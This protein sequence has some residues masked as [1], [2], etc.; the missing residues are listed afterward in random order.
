MDNAERVRLS[1][2]QQQFMKHIGAELKSIDMGFCE[3]HLPFNA[4]LTQ[5]NG[6][7]HA[8]TIGT[9]ADT[10]GGY[11]AYSTMQPGESVLTVEYKL[12]LLA[13]AKGDLLIVRSNV[14]KAGRTLTVCTSNVFVR[15]NEIENLC[16]TAMVTLIA[17]K[18]YKT[19]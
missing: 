16:A 5:Q 8:G 6:Y 10:A 18:N 15:S 12:N 7:F 2:D 4:N 19:K 9:I 13:P 17:L 14:V 3:I 11:A 1:F